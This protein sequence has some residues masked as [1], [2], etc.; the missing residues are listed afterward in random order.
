MHHLGTPVTSGIPAIDYFLSSELLEPEDGDDDYTEELVRLKKVNTFYYNPTQ[1]T[2]VRDRGYFGFDQDV[3]LYVCPQSLFK[4]HPGFDAVLAEILR[5]DPRG[6][7]VLIE[8]ACDRWKRLLAER[9]ERNHPVEARRIVFLPRLSTDAFLTSW[10]W[11]TCSWIRRISGWEHQL[12]G[13]RFRHAD[14]HAGGKGMR[15]RITGACYR[16]MGLSDCIAATDQEYAAIA[17]RLGKD[18]AWRDQFR[19]EILSRKHVLF[20]DT[21][22]VRELERFFLRAVSKARSRRG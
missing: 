22:A 6:R 20:E 21:E 3:S 1:D 5:G 8:G 13:L 14:R 2:T 11:P 16:Q 9:L 4:L 10:R 17:L 12:R 7:V 19:A 18:P 15:D